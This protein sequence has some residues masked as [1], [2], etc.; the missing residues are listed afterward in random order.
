VQTRGRRSDGT[1]EHYSFDRAGFTTSETWGASG[2]EPA[3]F[4]IGR[5]PATN[6]ATSLSLTCPDRMGRPLRHSSVVLPGHEEWLK[7]D[8]LRTHC[9]WTRRTWRNAG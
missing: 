7:W 4:I 3:S 5:D 8:L 2:S 9:S 6:V 1:W